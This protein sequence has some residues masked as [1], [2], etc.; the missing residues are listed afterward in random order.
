MNRQQQDFQSEVGGGNLLETQQ[1]PQGTLRQI[2]KK[3][4]DQVISPETRHPAISLFYGIFACAMLLHHVYV[5]FYYI[6]M[7]T[8]AEVFSIPWIIFAV[9]TIILGQLWKDKA[10][11]ILVPLLLIRTLRIDASIEEAAVVQHEVFFISLYAYFG[12]YG[13]SRVFNRKDLKRF[14]AAFCCLWTVAMVVFSCISI[15]VGWTGVTVKTLGKS[16]FY[17]RGSR[18]QPAYHMVCG[19]LMA[20]LGIATAFIGMSLTKRKWIKILYI[21]ALIIIYIGGAV[22][23]TRTGYILNGLA[24]SIL[25]TLYL[26]KKIP[27]E[28]I[29]IPILR[30]CLLFASFAA[31]MTVLLIAQMRFLTLFNNVRANYQGLVINHAMAEAEEVNNPVVLQPRDLVLDQG[32]NALL[33]N[34]VHIWESAI[35]V[36]KQDP[37]VLLWG[38]SAYKPMTAFKWYRASLGLTK[39]Y[40]THNFMLQMIYE[41]GIP[42]LLLLLAFYL[43]FMIRAVKVMKNKSLPLWARYAP[44]PAILC[45]LTELID[46]LCSTTTG[47]PPMTTLYV[48]IGLTAAIYAQEKKAKEPAAVIS[49]SALM[50]EKE[51]MNNEVLQS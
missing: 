29:R 46:I 6:H 26:T 12:C 40:H 15:Y 43:I 35:E 3:I 30:Y 23:V 10:A 50:H 27:R 2:A 13:V 22:T 41:N 32:W 42:A 31:A 1:E 44:I 14:I 20:S 37:T 17:V 7:P 49:A 8:G 4:Y 48:F 45:L 38:N 33:N 39:Y 5:T 36:I 34:R 25:L 18:V 24:V 9:L 51:G 16:K 21:P 28:K 47:F 19:G 11:W